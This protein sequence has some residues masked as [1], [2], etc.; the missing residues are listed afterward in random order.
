MTPTRL[1]ASSHAMARFKE[2]GGSSVLRKLGQMTGQRD[3]PRGAVGFLL[4]QLVQMAMDDRP[5][6]VEQVF[7]KTAHAPSTLVNFGIRMHAN[8]EIRLVA[9]VRDWTIITVLEPDMVTQNKGGGL[10]RRSDGSEF[11]LTVKLPGLTPLTGEPVGYVDN[12]EVYQWARAYF[13]KTR[14]A[15]VMGAMKVANNA[16]PRVPPVK[17]V[18]ARARRDVQEAE[19]VVKKAQ[20]EAAGQQQQWARQEAEEKRLVEEHLHRHLA[21]PL[22][23]PGVVPEKQEPFHAGFH[24]KFEKAVPP[25]VEVVPIMLESEEV[26]LKGAAKNLLAILRQLGI[27]SCI[28]TV[29]DGSDGPSA[30]WEVEYKR[31]GTGK[32]AL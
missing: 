18:F 28:L 19:A 7:D 3:T 26:Q 21:T 31:K 2:R 29:V 17:E 11:P 30:E 5:D 4:E 1:Q 14:G 25:V 32:A 13:E 16:K 6:L 10:Y 12:D 8:R 15:S 27:Q 23:K 9:L 24:E 20:A 22:V